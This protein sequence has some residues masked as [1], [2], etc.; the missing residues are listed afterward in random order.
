MRTFIQIVMVPVVIFI[1]G[2]ILAAICTL[3]MLHQKPF[4]KE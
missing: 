4:F 3:S 2:L 1:M